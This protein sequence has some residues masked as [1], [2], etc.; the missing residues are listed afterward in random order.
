VSKKTLRDKTSRWLF[1]AIRLPGILEADEAAARLGIPTHAI[2]I[3]IG[4]KHLKPLGKPKDKSSKKFSSDYIEG[5][6]HDQKWLDK[7]VR[8]IDAYWSSQ[9]EKR[10]DESEL[11]EQAKAA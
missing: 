7:A 5:L 4:A 2:P 11:P 10:K 9:N 6:V 8:I 3:L 1:H